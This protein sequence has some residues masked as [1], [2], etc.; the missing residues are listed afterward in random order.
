VHFAA[1]NIDNSGS[2]DKCAGF[3]PLFCRAT[4]TGQS[5]R[6]PKSANSADA[7]CTRWY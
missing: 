5:R 3:E 7:D 4:A 6:D 1:C 2:E